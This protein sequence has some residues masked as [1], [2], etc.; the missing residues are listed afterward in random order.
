MLFKSG[1]VIHRAFSPKDKPF[2]LCYV[3]KGTI[4]YINT[5]IFQGIVYVFKGQ[6]A[7]I[8]NNQSLQ[9]SNL[10]PL[11]ST[12]TPIRKYNEGQLFGE[13]AIFLSQVS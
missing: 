12:M 11:I 8:V 7:L 4:H 1:E 6:D 13:A 2:G 9:S 3:T 5:F 10:L